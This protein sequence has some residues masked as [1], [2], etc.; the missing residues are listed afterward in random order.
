MWSPGR[1]LLVDGVIFSFTLFSHAAMVYICPHFRLPCFL[2]NLLSNPRCAC[3]ARVTVV[4]LSVGLC[5]CS[6]RVAL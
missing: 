2:Q 4:A 1:L 6:L 5:V 3:V